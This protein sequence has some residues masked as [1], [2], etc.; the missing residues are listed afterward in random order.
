ME[1]IR[2]YVIKI[3]T[4]NNVLLIRRETVT[5]VGI[6]FENLVEYAFLIFYVY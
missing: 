1:K 6:D 4:V 3:H 2:T 5:R